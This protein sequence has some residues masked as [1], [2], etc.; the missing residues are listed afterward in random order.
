[1]S[2]LHEPRFLL[3]SAIL[4]VIIRIFRSHNIYKLSIS[5]IKKHAI[6][7]YYIDHF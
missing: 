4:S 5:K 2:Y 1:M 3:Y 6:V 7:I